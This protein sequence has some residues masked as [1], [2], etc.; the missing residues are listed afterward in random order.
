MVTMT[1]ARKEPEPEQKFNLEETL[2][3]LQLLNLKPVIQKPA[4]EATQPLKETIEALS[5]AQESV[6]A[7]TAQ[8]KTNDAVL[9]VNEGQQ[10]IRLAS[11]ISHLKKQLEKLGAEQVGGAPTYG[12]YVESLKKRVP[13]AETALQNGNLEGALKV[14]GEM[15]EGLNAFSEAISTA[16]G[17]V[18]AGAPQDVVA[19]TGK[20]LEFMCEGQH[21]RA[22]LILTAA[23]IIAENA[24]YFRSDAG[25]AGMEMLGKQ[26]AA[27]ADGTQQ[28]DVATIAEITRGAEELRMDLFYAP[29]QRAADVQAIRKGAAVIGSGTANELAGALEEWNN[30]GDITTAREVADRSLAYIRMAQGTKGEA[31]PKLEEIKTALVRYAKSGAKEAAEQYDAEMSAYGFTV[32]AERLGKTAAAWG[33]GAQKNVVNGALSRIS[34]L[35]EAGRADDAR[36]LLGFTAMYADSVAALGGVKAPLIGEQTGNLGNMARAMNALGR[37]EKEVEGKEATGMFMEGYAATQRS[38]QEIALR[39]DYS[40]IYGKFSGEMPWV[41][42]VAAGQLPFGEKKPDGTY[43]DYIDFAGL[44]EFDRTVA[45]QN[46]SQLLAACREAVKNGDADAFGKA[47]DSFQQRLAMVSFRYKMID[48][49]ERMS[50]ELRQDGAIRK[51]Y[52]PDPPAALTQRLDALDGQM[53]ELV[54]KLHRAGLKDTLPQREYAAVCNAMDQEKRLASGAGMVLYQLAQNS[55]YAKELEGTP[56]RPLL[57]APEDSSRS[58][59]E[60]ARQALAK[61]NISE[62]MEEYDAAI[63]CRQVALGILMKEF[64]GGVGEARVTRPYAFWHDMHMDVFDGLLSGS[65]GTKLDNLLNGATIL[66]SSVFDVPRTGGRK[67]FTNFRPM[68]NDV[69]NLT[70]QAFSAKS[71]DVMRGLLV[72][73]DKRLKEMQKIADK[74]QVVANIGTSVVATV[75][76]AVPGMQPVGI[77]MFSAMALKQA[78]EEMVA[79]GHMTFA[80]G[81]ALATITLTGPLAAVA[82]DLR[83]MAEAA[84]VMGAA[85]R[86]VVL[87]TIGGTAGAVNAG[88]NTIFIGTMA[89]EAG[90]AWIEG[91][92]ADVAF[93]IG[94]L[95]FPLAFAL[96]ARGAGRRMANVLYERKLA[97]FE[98]QYQ[99]ELAAEGRFEVRMPARKESSMEDIYKHYRK[100]GMFPH[101]VTPTSEHW[102]YIA[103]KSGTEAVPEK[104]VPKFTQENAEKKVMGSKSEELVD[105]QR[106]DEWVAEQAR[107]EEFIIGEKRTGEVIKSVERQTIETVRGGVELDMIAISGDKRWLNWIN[108]FFGEGWGDRTLGAYMEVIRRTM[109]AAGVNGRYMIRVSGRSDETLM[110]LVC[111]K[112]TGDAVR[113][114]LLGKEGLLART[115]REVLREYMDPEHPQSLAPLNSLVKIPVKLVSGSFDV[116]EAVRVRNEKGNVIV[117]HADGTTRPAEGFL[118]G[119]C[120]SA[121]ETEGGTASF[122]PK[123][124]KALGIPEA[125]VFVKDERIKDMAGMELRNGIPLEVRYEITVPSVLEEV[126]TLLQKT[127]KGVAEILTN[128]FGIRGLNTF[129]GHYGTN[130]VLSIGE[131]AIA[132]YAEMNHLTIRRLGTHKYLVEKGTKQQIEELYGYI[133][134][135]MD[136]TGIRLRPSNLGPVG[137][138]LEDVTADM[139]LNSI[140]NGHLRRRWNMV[141]YVDA[142]AFISAVGMATEP[143]LMK[144]L[145]AD[146]RGMKELIELV[147]KN[148]AIRNVEDLFMALESP[149]VVEPIKGRWLTMKFERYVLKKGHDFWSRSVELVPRLER[150]AVREAE[151]LAPAV[152]AEAETYVPPVSDAREWGGEGG[153]RRPVLER[154]GARPTA[155]E[156]ERPLAALEAEKT[157]IVGDLKKAIEIKGPY[158]RIVELET[159]KEGKVFKFTVKA[160]DGSTRKMIY[161]VPQYR[162]QEIGIAM[163]KAAGEGQKVPDYILLEDGTALQQYVG[164]MPLKDAL[165]TAA[166]AERAELLRLV[167]RQGV[168]D[169]A[170]GIP[171]PHSQNYMVAKTTAGWE[172]YRI[173]LENSGRG[174]R[175]PEPH[176]KRD[177]SKFIMNIR[178]GLDLTKYAEGEL[179]ALYA[180]IG[181]GIEAVGRMDRMAVVKEAEGFIG[182][183]LRDGKAVFDKTKRIELE[184]RI[185]RIQSEP[186]KIRQEMLTSILWTV[187]VVAVN[188]L[189][190]G[191]TLAANPFVKEGVGILLKELP[192]ARA[193]ELKKWLKSIENISKEGRGEVPEFIAEAKER[194]NSEI[195][196]K[197]SAEGG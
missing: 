111:E 182:T 73:A 65:G 32:A 102:R 193:E 124:R 67:L 92:K 126:T 18:S 87:G 62:A 72:T 100:T 66:E 149:A 77:A 16:R 53:Q 36:V 173:D 33:P 46:M 13:E 45:G 175:R 148:P 107:R 6:A 143:T 57:T 17:L 71:E 157:A 56:L 83:V 131:K 50:K 150:E 166:P 42:G 140:A 2:R 60:A 138:A 117:E 52:G 186:Q 177:N 7:A 136:A 146:Y 40:E 98:R 190:R 103:K 174:W 180:G 82:R 144:L 195:A 152:G 122:A 191:I 132:D 121:E 165:I 86:A 114:S 139:A 25:K 118:S 185:A 12:D 11:D 97:K 99:L 169:Y 59:L 94:M 22:D 68:Q 49:L 75:M 89:Q 15:Q 19:A 156:L 147:N 61:A 14:F 155:G 38:A 189:D 164:K 178:N 181:E 1:S 5:R 170:L 74:N 30:E 43:P 137:K 145:G 119:L 167:G 39:K 23:K 153:Q 194:L 69:Y 35:A 81:T 84:R 128:M 10:R 4:A 141:A 78:M 106:M 47:L 79:R 27:Y 80:T 105:P 34:E 151:L 192:N 88:L 161:S 163:Y 176:P 24:E 29:E 134:T 90:M 26:I 54:A 76:T 70:E 31:P 104:A 184:K 113:A 183:K 159:I 123:L 115:T 21:D 8:A 41:K 197:A 158:G 171:D 162:E 110:M 28:M 127:D 130:A 168:I 154:K 44:R 37:G 51:Q 133:A 85:R 188:G 93:N 135:Q 95:A 58:H 160:M 9:G 142:N 125:D 109:A 48:G 63:Y 112:G 108:N 55:K 3:Q 172:I 101:G 187:E 116:S 96:G 129:F 196:K 91:R 179:N 20:A 120:S 64:G